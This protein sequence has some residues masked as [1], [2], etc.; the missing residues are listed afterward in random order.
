MKSKKRRK[1]MSDFNPSD[2][3]RKAI[4]AEGENY[5]ISAGAGSGK[6]AVLT[7]RIFRLVKERQR[8][9]NFLVLTFT[10]LAAGEMKERVRGLLLEDESTKKFAVEVDNTH[11]ETFDSFYL[12]LARKYFYILGIDKNISIISEPIVL[13]KQR[14]LL[15]ELFF[16][17]ILEENPKMIELIKSFSLKDNEPVKK[18]IIQILNSA[19]NKADKEQYYAHLRSDFSGEEF[20]NNIIK[21]KY[22]LLID[23]IK[24]LKEKVK[25]ANL[26]N[27]DDEAQIIDYLNKLLEFPDYCSLTNFLSVKENAFPNRKAKIYHYDDPT[28]R[29]ALADFFN[30]KI[31]SEFLKEEEIKDTLS[32]NQEFVSFVL[33]IAINIDQQI[34]DFK[35]KHNAYSFAD[36]SRMVLKLFKDPIIVKEVSSQFDYIMVDEYQDTNDIQEKVLNIIGRNNIYMVG[37]VK[38]SIYRF[39]N[40]DCAIFNQKY[41]DYKNCNGGKEIDLNESFRSREDVVDFINDAFSRIMVKENNPIDY[42]NG[43]HFK[44]G[45]KKYGPKNKVYETEE[46]R[47]MYDKAGE[48][49]KIESEMIV[50][51]II[52][53]IN[54]KFEVYDFKLGKNRPVK[55][56]D[57]AIIIDRE[58]DFDEF[59]KTFADYNVPLKS[60]GKEE[61]MSSDVT[62]AIKSLLKLLYLALNHDYHEE[63]Q[64]AFISVARSFLVE[65]SD[66]EIYKT[67]K[68]IKDSEVLLNTFAQ[69]IEL[70]KEKCRFASLYEILKTLYEEFDLYGSLCKITNYYPNVH[71][72][73][74]LLDYA[75]QMDALGLSLK[76][77]VDYF[78]N[79]ANYELDIDYRDNDSQD[80]SVTLINIHQSKGLEYNVVYYPL[81]CRNFISKQYDGDFF[82]SKKYGLIFPDNK[83]LLKG[84][85]IHQEKKEEIEEKI[86][87]LYVALTRAKQ[88]IVLIIGNKNASKPKFKLPYESKSLADIY[89]LS[90]IGDK[91]LKEFNLSEKEISLDKIEENVGEVKPIEVREYILES[92]LIKKE[93]A[94]KEI[95]KVDEDLL[96]FGTRVHATLEGLDFTNR[97]LNKYQD[98][99]LKRIVNN[100][101]SSPLLKGVSNEMVKPEFKYY[102]EINNVTGIVDCLVEKETEL[103]IIDYKLKNI[104][105]EEYEKQLRTYYKYFSTITKK[106][107]KMYLLAALTGEIKEV[108][109]E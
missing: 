54:N 94:S 92:T 13:I 65:M 90:D 43:H 32:H 1:T 107:I 37:D 38:Q 86:R 51:D 2:E 36:I 11:I 87:L 48:C 4:D 67:Y 97:D 30:D 109:N 47:Y 12:F 71:K 20:T 102:D 24:F 39:R 58:R 101:L 95:V 21:E 53:K 44:F 17:Y 33:D 18:F 40:A 103:L 5:L 96:L 85:H 105:D 104:D 76:D 83:A 50:K 62:V 52:N 23:S 8:L 61:L 77:L 108:K 99:K 84:L 3:Q 82:V 91:Y 68:D 16:K 42:S 69:K 75:K 80:N 41:L 74:V 26:E 35:K 22:N 55:F 70:F 93:K 106:P 6:T 59:R 10:D 49:S 19:N 98:P 88:K 81:L 63:Y 31:L 46:Y 73:E 60:C 100:V 29:N 78:D 79:L 15:D 45:Q 72:A 34:D 89:R 56:S 27:L 25:N 57:F 64:H 14:Q 7:R 9:D 66:Q 28:T